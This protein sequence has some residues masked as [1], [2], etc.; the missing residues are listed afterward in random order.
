MATTVANSAVAGP[1]NGQSQQLGTAPYLYPQEQQQLQ[2]PSNSMDLFG[3]QPAVIVDMPSEQEILGARFREADGMLQAWIQR[4]EKGTRPVRSR[5]PSVE[6]VQFVPRQQVGGGAED[7]AVVILSECEKSHRSRRKKKR[8][9]TR[10]T[11]RSSS[12][13][14]N[15]SR[16]QHKKRYRKKRSRSREKSGF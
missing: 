11:S 4:M 15:D 10:S 8:R 5:H 2:Q 16:Y 3:R 7:D 1:I 12:E 9:R 13:N 14:S 6:E